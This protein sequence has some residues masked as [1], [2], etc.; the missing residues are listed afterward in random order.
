M[1][2]IPKS[3]KGVLWSADISKLDLERDKVYIIHQVLSYG[4]LSEIKWLL[5]AYGPRVVCEVFLKYPQ[6]VYTN[7]GFAFIKN[8]V[9]GL[10]RVDIGE[11]RYVQAFY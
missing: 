5:A 9:L 8:A 7:A 11:D 3:L 2:K 10:R 4:S 1:R 6:K